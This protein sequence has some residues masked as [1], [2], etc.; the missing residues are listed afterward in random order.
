MGRTSSDYSI[1]LFTCDW[2][3][4]G[5]Q[6]VY[7]YHIQKA[8][9]LICFALACLAVRAHKCVTCRNKN[10]CVSFSAAMPRQVVNIT[11]WPL[12][13]SMRRCE[14]FLLHFT[15][16]RVHSPSINVQRDLMPIFR[17]KRREER[18][19]EDKR[20]SSVFI[21]RWDIYYSITPWM[22]KSGFCK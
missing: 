16:S 19:W 15:G 3:I 14:F 8:V 10:L 18:I 12:T 2:H 17:H 9:L 6:W 11:L 1:V 22:P 21:N 7:F 5:V 20:S 13:H 4:K